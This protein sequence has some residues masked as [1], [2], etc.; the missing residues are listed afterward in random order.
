MG[1][2]MWSFYRT[3][4]LAIKIMHS[5]LKFYCNMFILN[6]F[7]GIS[8]AGYGFL[9]MREI[10]YLLGPCFSFWLACP[11]SVKPP[12][13]AILYNKKVVPHNFRICSLGN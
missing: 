10:G 11:Q 4:P 12:R 13:I 5:K 9:Y 8:F 2:E 3:T 7:S 1:R 6:V